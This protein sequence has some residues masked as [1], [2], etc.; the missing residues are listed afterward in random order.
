MI[1]S[2]KATINVSLSFFPLIFL[3]SISNKFGLILGL[4]CVLILFIKNIINKNLGV[5]TTVLLVYFVIS[6]ILYFYF[7]MDFILENRHLISYIVLC[8]MGFTSVILKKPYT[9][10]EARSSYG[11]DFGKSP[12]FIE[13]NSLITKLWSIIYLINAFLEL[14]GHNTSIII[15]ANIIIVLGI[16]VSIMIPAALPE[17]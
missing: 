4:V 2:L 11:K 10:Y 8:C 6:N 3:W 12:L 17:V 16:T 1:K 13:V 14:L 5:M 15:I 9:M 7:K